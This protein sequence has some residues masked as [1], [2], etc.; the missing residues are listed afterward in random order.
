MPQH[1]DPRVTRALTDQLASSRALGGAGPVKIIGYSSAE[2]EG[3][4]MARILQTFTVERYGEHK[5]QRKAHKHVKLRRKTKGRFT[6]GRKRRYI[7]IR[8]TEGGGRENGEPT[9]GGQE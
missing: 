7:V 2:I 3:G 8:H 6:D 4:E 1:D 9:E 5:A